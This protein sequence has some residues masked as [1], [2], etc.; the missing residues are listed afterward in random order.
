VFFNR[1]NYA[2][3]NLKVAFNML[4][5]VSTRGIGSFSEFTVDINV[6]LLIVRNRDSVYGVF[7]TSMLKYC[8]S[9]WPRGIRHEMSSLARTLGSWIL[10]PLKAWMFVCV[11]SVFV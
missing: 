4:R 1:N 5:S 8:R 3:N 6:I 2:T 10:I 11:Y 9:E 7:L